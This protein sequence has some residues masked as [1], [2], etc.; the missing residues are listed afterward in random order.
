M[1]EENFTEEISQDVNSEPKILHQNNR[2]EEDEQN[3]ENTE[4]EKKD[5]EKDEISNRNDNGKIE[6]FGNDK[7]YPEAGITYNIY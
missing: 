2:N 1:I 7:C 4:E 6:I 3:L 5:A